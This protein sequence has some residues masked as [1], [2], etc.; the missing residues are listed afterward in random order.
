MLA[1]NGTIYL[2]EGVEV[3]GEQTWSLEGYGDAKIMRYAGYRGV[4]AMITLA[5]GA[6]LTLEHIIIDGNR[7]ALDES[8]E[9]DE[10]WDAE[11]VGNRYGTSCSLTLKD[12]CVLQ[13]NYTQR[14]CNFQP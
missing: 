2:C 5:D 9:S 8:D 11:I 10:F 13:N 1:E 6:D 12:G 4:V 3:E 14:F 7:E